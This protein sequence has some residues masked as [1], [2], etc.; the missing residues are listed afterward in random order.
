M[1]CCRGAADPGAI[2]QGEA[3]DTR[4]D[5]GGDTRLLQAWADPDCRPSAGIQESFDVR[6]VLPDGGDGGDGGDGALVHYEARMK[7]GKAI[8]NAEYLRY[9]GDKLA[10]VEVYFGLG[11]GETPTSPTQS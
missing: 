9:R 7:S 2:V 1:S 11:P 10:S 3:I 8:R 5:E 4:E 6:L